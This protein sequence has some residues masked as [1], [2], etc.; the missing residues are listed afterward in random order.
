MSR[1][2]RIKQKVSLQKY[3]NA[4]YKAANIPHQANTAQPLGLVL[5]Q[6][7][8]LGVVMSPKMNQGRRVN[9]HRPPQQHPVSLLVSENE[10]SGLNFNRG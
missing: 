4:K 8:E 5:L 9:Y 3:K 7:W 2:N 10:N 1:P 6:A